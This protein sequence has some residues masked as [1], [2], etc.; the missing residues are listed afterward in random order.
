MSE[1]LEQTIPEERFTVT[2]DKTAEWCIQRILEAK[3]E[4]QKW[5]DFYNEQIRKTADS[6]DGTISFM[7]HCLE[8]YF[9]TVPHKETATEEN[10]RLPSGKLVMKKPSTSFEKD[11]NALL[12]W[13]KKNGHSEFIKTKESV[14]WDSLKKTLIVVGGSVTDENGEIVPCVTAVEKPAEFKLGK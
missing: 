11:D 3:E 4:K 5:T 8:E 13:L 2:D 10:Y 12:E 6:C 9:G 1:M 7:M 14:D